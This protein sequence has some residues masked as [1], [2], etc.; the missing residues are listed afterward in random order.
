MFGFGWNRV[1]SQTDP[2]CMSFPQTER[3]YEQVYTPIL[4]EELD[5]VIA[6]DTNLDKD[7]EVDQEDLA[8]LQQVISGTWTGHMG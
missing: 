4:I 5:E 1:Y 6:F 3:I 2:P 7:Q 8:D